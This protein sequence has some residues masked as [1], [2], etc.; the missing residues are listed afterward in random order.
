MSNIQVVLGILAPW[1]GNQPVHVGADDAVF[2]RS[3][4]QARKAVQ[5]TPGL[6]L[7]LLRHMGS[8]DLLAELVHLHCLLVT[9]TQFL[10]N[11]FHLL[12]QEI[13][14]LDLFDPRAGLV[15]DFSAQV[16]G[17]RFRAPISRPVFPV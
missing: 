11:G 8:F 15:L 13:F 14:P 4:G 12:A 2:S 7:G 3:S 10:L 6:F 16:R 1:Q 5:F 9:L 17:H